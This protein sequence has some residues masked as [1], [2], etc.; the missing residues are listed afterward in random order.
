MFNT[1]KDNKWV[2]AVSGG[3]DSMALL[4]MCNQK[5]LDI[6]VAH[7]NYKV[8]NTANRDMNCVLNYCK[9]H[10]IECCVKERVEEYSGNFQAWAREYRYEFF[11]ELVNK[12]GCKGVL[13]AHHMDDVIETYYMQLIRN[14]VVSY[15]GIKEE[16]IIKDVLIKRILLDYTKE[17]LI[18]YCIKNDVE[19]HDDE[20]NFKTTYL[21]NKLR[22]LEVNTYSKQDKLTIIDAVN[23]LNEVLSSTNKQVMSEYS[24]WDKSLLF[25]K[26][27]EHM[28][29]L[30]VSY[31]KHD[32]G[33]Y[34]ISKNS[35]V[36]LMRCINSSS[37]WEIL[38]SNQIIVYDNYGFIDWM[39]KDADDYV[40]VLD[41][42]KKMKTEYFELSN[43]GSIV[44]GVTLSA[45]DYPIRIRNA[46]KEDQIKMRF[47]TKKI[48]RYFIDKKISKKE[49]KHWPVVENN[50]GNIVF[51]C[52]IG[53]D[54]QHFSN[55]PTI[56]VL[57]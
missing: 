39:S 57:K 25:L 28:Y 51:I 43:N 20:S 2:V 46:K 30:L 53:C 26:N 9:K 34:N 41:D 37:N 49:R 23:D 52:G 4:D 36:E 48:N 24:Q 29:D 13:V 55:N 47:G 5:G 14:S 45:S 16:G 22:K 38:V 42:I 8:R 15:Y 17:E 31:L 6:V 12:Y 56:Y 7:I 18:N 11:K 19:Y 40:Y 44:E 21:R 33:L 35:I 50:M 10:N 27:S 54:V 1:L 3:C 32:A